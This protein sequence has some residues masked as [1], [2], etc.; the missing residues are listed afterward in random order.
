[1]CEKKF[2]V[3]CQFCNASGLILNEKAN[4]VVIDELVH[5]GCCLSSDE[6]I[7]N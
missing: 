7:V 6:V 4:L 3:V 5:D 1:M 2:A